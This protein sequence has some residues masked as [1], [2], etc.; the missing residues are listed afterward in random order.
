MEE[1][2]QVSNL[3][4]LTIKRISNRIMPFLIL[5]FIMAFLD[6]INIGF[7]AIHMNDAIGITQ[8]IF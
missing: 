6:R 3:E 5:L 1:I 7:A 2:K 8:T 4:K